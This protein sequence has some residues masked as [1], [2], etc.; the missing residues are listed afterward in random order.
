MRR[1]RGIDEQQ[2]TVA[3]LTALVDEAESVRQEVIRLVS[4]LMAH[5]HGIDAGF[6]G[7]AELLGEEVF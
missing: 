7:A 1:Y 6:A 2:H 3:S 5:F 4:A